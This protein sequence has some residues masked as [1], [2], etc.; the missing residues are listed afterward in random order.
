LPIKRYMALGYL[1]CSD[2]LTPHIGKSTDLLKQ[3]KTTILNLHRTLI[4]SSDDY[5]FIP[6]KSKNKLNDLANSEIST[7]PRESQTAL[8]KKIIYETLL[9]LLKGFVEIT[10]PAIITAKSIVDLVKAVY[11]AIIIAVETGFNAAMSG[12][13]AVID[14]AHSAKTQ[15][16]ISVAIGGPTLDASWQTIKSNLESSESID[17]EEA[18]PAFD[19][20]P[21]N[22]TEWQIDV[23]ASFKVPEDV[24]GV[25]QDEWDG[26]VEAANSLN[27]LITQ[28]N[29]VDQE[30]EKAKLEKENLEKDYEMIMN[31]ED[32]ESGIKGEMS[33]IFGSNYLLPATYVALLPS[34]TPYLGGIIPPPFVIGPPGTF[35]GMIYLILLMSDAYDFLEAEETSKE[36]GDPNCDDEL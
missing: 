4:A 32:G 15:L 31:G 9:L 18:V 20:S 25:T 27:D 16:E 5:T 28:L 35:P 22:V 10:D 3:T 26:F 11:E 7:K 33:D 29:S 21:E 13:Q 2:V 24:P 8:I 14:A 30:L 12:F 17:V 19:V 34:M 36:K 1:Y 23:N 6:D